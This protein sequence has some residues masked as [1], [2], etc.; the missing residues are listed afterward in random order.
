M[1]IVRLQGGLGNQ[2]FQYAF[3]KSLS[4]RHNVDLFLDTSLLGNDSNDA[5]IVLRHFDLDIFRIKEQF[6]EKSLIVKFNGTSKPSLV[7]RIQ[8]KV[9]RILDRYPLIIQHHHDFDEAVITKIGA[10]ACIVGR[11]QSELYFL[12][13]K[14]TIKE[15]F[16]PSVLEPNKYTKSFLSNLQDKVTVGIQVRRGDYITHPIYSTQ[17]GALNFEYYE[18][19]ITLIK[20]KLPLQVLHFV[21]VSDDI[22]YCKEVFA[23]VENIHF[24]EQEK[25]KSGFVSDFWLLS[26]C[27]HNIISNSTFAWW[28]AWIGENENSIV[29]A[30]KNWAITKRF[31]PPFIIPERWIAVVNTFG[32]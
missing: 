16:N 12:Q 23:D 3:A 24:V 15:I 21:V 6:A 28:A 13:H 17:L 26:Q 31:S 19:A 20:S 7:Q 1:I 32:N 5:N 9:N 27:E 10:D 4:L 25:S 30:P 14:A 2:M 11:W 8:F 22:E 18:S 29:I